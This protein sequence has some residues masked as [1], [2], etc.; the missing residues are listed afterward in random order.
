MAM[1][2]VDD[3]SLIL[4]FRKFEQLWYFSV[5]KRVAG[6]INVFESVPVTFRKYNCQDL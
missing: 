6:V 4:R 2:V 3:M 1:T 5:H